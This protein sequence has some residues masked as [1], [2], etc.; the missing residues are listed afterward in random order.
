MEVFQRPFMDSPHPHHFATNQAITWTWKMGIW[1][2]RANLARNYYCWTWK[3]NV[4][5]CLRH[6]LAIYFHL[7]KL[8]FELGHGLPGK[9]IYEH[10][11]SLT[12]MIWMD[13]FTGLG[14]FYSEWKI[15]KWHEILLCRFT[16]LCWE[17]TAAI[18]QKPGSQYFIPP[19]GQF[20]VGIIQMILLF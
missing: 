16:V 2:S 8:V 19:C 12:F 14:L 20:F 1:I 18:I 5:F 10:F 11:G 15:K 6:K 7:K 9:M 17:I 13:I 4:F 3:I